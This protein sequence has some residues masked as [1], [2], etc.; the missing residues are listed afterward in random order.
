MEIDNFNSNKIER[1]DFRPLAGLSSKHL[2]TILPVYLSPGEIPPT[3]TW[4]VPLDE[5][6]AL[7]CEVSKPV[8]WKQTDKTVLLVHGLG[9]S[10]SSSYM[11]RMARKLYHKGIKVV[12][13][14][15]RGCGSGRGLSTRPYHGGNSHD[16]LT[17]L[18]FCQ[19]QAP[20]SETILVGFSLGGNIALKL[21][22]ELGEEAKRWLKSCIAICPP[23]DLFESVQRIRER[24]Y[25]LYHRH[26]LLSL[27]KQHE[28]WLLEKPMTLFEIDEKMTAP[29]WGYKG[30]FE[31]YQECSSMTFLPKIRHT[32]RVLLSEDDP[33]IDPGKIK[34]LDIP[35]PVKVFITARGG[36][37]GFIGESLKKDSFYWLDELLGQWID[38]DF[39]AA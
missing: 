26:Y 33:F 1:L 25:W 15:L 39:T 3:E 2:Q 34:H 6:D 17:V 11:I 24:K 32:T 36:H 14:N 7:S 12:R 31:F 9:G 35:D 29:I 20:H 38:Q 21:L 19:K 10:D 30:A 5:K 22:G 16:I 28:S 27:I 37:M 23:L 13:I 4:I 18:D 8:N